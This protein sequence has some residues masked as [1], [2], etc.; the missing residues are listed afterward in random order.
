MRPL[1]VLTFL[2]T[3]PLAAGDIPPLPGLHHFVKVNEHLYRGA[4][5]APAGFHS[6]AQLGVHAVIDLREIGARSVGEEKEVET[7]GMKYYSVPMKPLSAPTDKQMAVVLALV[8]DSAN[9]PVFVHCQRGK[10]RTGTVVACYRVT[11]DHWPN[12]RALEE[13]NE[14]G[15]S[16]VE[17][18][19]RAFILRFQQAGD[20]TQTVTTK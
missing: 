16:R 1:L 12:E 6:L 8:E 3:M 7:L 18:G 10:D 2:A 20:L 11:H 17:R 4:Q 9:W 5:P 14:G 19:M 13:A 15:L